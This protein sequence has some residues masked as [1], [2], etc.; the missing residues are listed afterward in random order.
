MHKFFQDQA[1]A[2]AMG[3]PA[4]QNSQVESIYG[5]NASPRE[6]VDIVVDK[7]EDDDHVTKTKRDE[8]LV[9]LLKAQSLKVWKKQD[10]KYH[11][12]SLIAKY[13]F[14][15]ALIKEANKASIDT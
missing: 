10:N 12:S 3:D 4:F 1:Y 5:P 8:V 14:H 15:D 11:Q 2:Q 13:Y 9:G 7:P 6:S